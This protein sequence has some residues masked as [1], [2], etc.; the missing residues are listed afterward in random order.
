[1]QL[2]DELR[3]LGDPVMIEE[4][5]TRIA[6]DYFGADRCFYARIEDGK[7]IVTRDAARG[8][9]PLVAGVYP[10]E[11]FTIFDSIVKAGRPFIV[12]DAR[13]SEIIDDTL[14]QICLR[15]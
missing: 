6:M 3:S 7:A 2:N 10:L 9:L 15:L 13:D 1:M 8:G 4:T 11:S 5:V 14:R 12:A